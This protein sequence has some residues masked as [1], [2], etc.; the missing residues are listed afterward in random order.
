MPGASN[1]IPVGVTVAGAQEAPSAVPRQDDAGDLPAA[2]ARSCRC[3]RKALGP[4][5][6]VVPGHGDV[7]LRPSAV[8]SH[9]CPWQRPEPSGLGSRNRRPAAATVN[10]CRRPVLRDPLIRG[11]AGKDPVPWQCRSSRLRAPEARCQRQAQ[12]EAQGDGA[13]KM[14]PH[15]ST[16]LRSCPTPGRAKGTQGPPKRA[17]WPQAAALAH[18]RRARPGAWN[19]SAQH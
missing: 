5:D 10:S 2:R 13:R 4:G 16:S 14:V 9:P 3:G 8:G 19:G 1:V 12:R 17:S 6:P 7:R 15:K 11:H 18:V